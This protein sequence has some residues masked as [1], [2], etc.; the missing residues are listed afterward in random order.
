[1]GIQVSI[2]AHGWGRAVRILAVA[3]LALAS[4]LAAAVAW[5]TV[6]APP[7]LAPSAD[8]LAIRQS[9]DIPALSRFAA[10]DGTSLAYRR[11]EGGDQQ[12]A[13]LVHGT[14]CESS[15]MHAVAKTI[16]KAG[17]SVYAVD[18]RGHGGSG[19]T[20]DISYIGQLDDDLVDLLK[21]IRPSHLRARTT[22]IG[23]SGGGALALRFAGG[24]YGDEFD[25]YVLISPAITY[26]AT[27]ARPDTGGW[28]KP[29]LP[30]I[31]GLLILNS[32][33][34]HAFDGLEALVFAV[35]P[36][37]RDMTRAYSFRLMRN[38][39]TFDYLAR[40]AHSKKPMALVAGADDEQFFADRYA[41]Q[42]TPAK[43]DLTID[44]VPSLGH[45]GMLSKPAGLAALGQI[46]VRLTKGVPG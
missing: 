44:L 46:F 25:H 7:P 36:G 22:L 18:L 10:R 37:T 45:S 24:P 26:P 2:G 29:H 11:Y 35:P 27:L 21:A 5:G 15:C 31:V 43:K 30:R 9:N 33:G 19:R 32:V 42:L 28:A 23:F 17:A 1:M 14:S 6:S 20:G 40:L 39:A 41:G 3:A 16:A 13:I 4:A 8:M 38:L 12:V 34:I